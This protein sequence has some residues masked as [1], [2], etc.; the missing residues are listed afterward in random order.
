[1]AQIK[2]FSIPIIDCLLIISVDSL[3][4]LR[5][6]YTKEAKNPCSGESQQNRD[7]VWSVGGKICHVKLSLS[8]L[9]Y[10]ELKT[11]KTQKTQEE[12][13]NFSLTALKN[14]DQGVPV[15]GA[16]ETNLTRNHEVVGSIPGFAQ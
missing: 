9:G 8:H 5:G 14:E 13:L 4:L 6:H 11:I 16:A 12:A 2:L 3:K 15:R 7:G 1:M 10:F